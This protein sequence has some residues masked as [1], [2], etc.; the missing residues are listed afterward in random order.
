MPF[1][2]VYL[3][4]NQAISHMNEQYHKYDH[5][6]SICYNNPIFFGLQKKPENLDAVNNVADERSGS[7]IYIYTSV[8][9]Y[10]CVYIQIHKYSYRFVYIYIIYI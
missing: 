2:N 5:R 1:E 6:V 7:H 8:Y 3:A 10:I 4:D 9:I